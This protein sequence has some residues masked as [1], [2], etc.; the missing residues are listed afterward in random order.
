MLAFAS[1]GFALLVLCL[2]VT[3]CGA[4]ALVGQGN[5]AGAIE[6]AEQRA[7]TSQHR[8]EYY[9]AREYLEKSREEAAEGQYQDA[10]RFADTSHRYAREL[11]ESDA[12]TPAP[13]S[14]RAAGSSR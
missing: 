1:R 6:R 8:F 5:A 14:T 13:A 3:S 12:Q 4:V 2:L 9:A 11:G 7:P 10:I